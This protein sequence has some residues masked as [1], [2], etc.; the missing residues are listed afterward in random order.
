MGQQFA[1]N[2]PGS[3]QDLVQRVDDDRNV[4]HLSSED[5]LGA[6]KS[7]QSSPQSPSS[8]LLGFDLS[9][10]KN[11]SQIVRNTSEFVQTTVASVLRQNL[12]PNS[13]VSS[14]AFH[15]RVSSS[16][17]SSSAV[18]QQQ[19]QSTAVSSSSVAA[20]TLTE[21]VSQS[22][23]KSSSTDNHELNHS[24]VA[25]SISR[26]PVSTSSVTSSS[27]PSS[28]LN[29]K[30]ISPKSLQRREAAMQQVALDFMRGAMDECTHIAN[31]S[32][33]VD[34]SLVIIVTAEKDAYVPRDYVTGL[35]ELWPG[36]ELR[37]VDAG[38]ISAY[39]FKQS[40]FRCVYVYTLPLYVCC[41]SRV[42]SYITVRACVFRQA[43][44]DA[45]ERQAKKYYSASL[46]KQAHAPS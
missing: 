25:D 36:A 15:D 7:R 17:T 32:R 30:S 2:Y 27:S 39:L 44:V 40:L 14:S 20:Q 31:F 38:H 8:S 43:I 22:P 4:S 10:L 3:L 13:Q 28:Q 6:A 26:H 42:A 23:I 45:M 1:R 33:P 9:S 35:D 11:F 29:A 18:Q 41:Y 12:A 16:S 24:Q 21:N 46:D 34:T 5:R 37:Y 19:Q